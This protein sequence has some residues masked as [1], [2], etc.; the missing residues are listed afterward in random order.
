M[1]EII[2]RNKIAKLVEPFT[3]VCGNNDYVI[4][5]S[6]DE[7]WDVY[8]TKTARFKWN[9]TYVDI[10]FIG[11]KCPMPAI[12]DAY[13]VEIGVYAG[14][15]HTTTGAYLPMKKSILC[16][17][18]LP[19]DPTPDVYAQIME[20][21]NSGGGGSTPG[22]TVLVD[23]ETIIMEDGVLS[24]NTTNDIEQDNTRPITSA[25]V[26]T[27]VGNIEVILQTI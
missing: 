19:A 14:D 11:N 26:Y 16:G 18:G 1:I 22:Q 8:E 25:G 3:A 23:N 6:F 21:L 15:L 7:E 10:V 20:L 13:G 4:K 27:T 17:G 12:N 9:S 24:V 2:I 5:F